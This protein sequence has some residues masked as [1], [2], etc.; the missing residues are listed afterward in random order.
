M[1]LHSLTIISLGL[2][3]LAISFGHFKNSFI[4]KSIS[5]LFPAWNFFDQ[6]TASPHLYYRENEKSEW[7]TLFAP[8]KSGLR[9]LFFNPDTNLYLFYHS[10]MQETLTTIFDGQNLKN[11]QF[12]ETIQFDLL[13]NLVLT[14]KPNA[15]SFKLALQ[16]ADLFIHSLKG[17]A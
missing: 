10:L 8:K 9:H 7:L 1:N 3:A 5:F 6:T 14:K 4:I 15:H 16:D 2:L 17:Q 13:K 11:F 12:E